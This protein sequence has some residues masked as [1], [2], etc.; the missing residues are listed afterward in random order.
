[1]SVQRNVGDKDLE[2]EGSLPFVICCLFLTLLVTNKNNAEGGYCST[3]RNAISDD[4][5]VRLKK[6]NCLRTI[7]RTI[8]TKEIKHGVDFHIERR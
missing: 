7:L 5:V 3:V 6:K 4:I 8:K 2:S 1:M